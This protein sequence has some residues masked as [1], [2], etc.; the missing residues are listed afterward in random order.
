[1]I[2][3][4]MVLIA[5]GIRT[6]FRSC[7]AGGATSGPPVPCAGSGCYHVASGCPRPVWRGSRWRVAPPTRP[8]TRRSSSR[9]HA[10]DLCDRSLP[11]R[12]RRSTPT[13]STAE[14]L[15]LQQAGSKSGKYTL[16]LKVSHGAVVSDNAPHGDLRQTRQSR[17]WARSNREHQAPRCRSPISSGCCRSRRPILRLSDPADSGPC[18]TRRPTGT[19]S[20]ELGLT[21]TGWFRTPPRSV[22]AV[23][24][25]K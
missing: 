16:R 4:L 12:S 19:R 6:C 10:D 7:P 9:A 14:K 24:A 20:R 23:V 25:E 18:P 5:I 3:L 2:T 11:V 22:R 1:M 17:T 21:F 8:T 13:C 15:A